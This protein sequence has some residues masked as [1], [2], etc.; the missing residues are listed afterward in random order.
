MDIQRTV[1]ITFVTVEYLN[2]DHFRIGKG[3]RACVWQHQ[4][5]AIHCQFHPRTYIYLLTLSF[6]RR[7]YILLIFTCR[8]FPHSET[9]VCIALVF[10]IFMPQ[11]YSH[12]NSSFRLSV[13]TQPLKWQF[14][15]ISPGPRHT[16]FST[17]GT[18]DTTCGLAASR[19]FLDS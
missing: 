11:P 19:E 9:N 5:N 3:V 18:L 4:P 1:R 16:P 7:S 17:L 6:S 12:L 15:V 10:F 8:F 14:K 13:N 2:L